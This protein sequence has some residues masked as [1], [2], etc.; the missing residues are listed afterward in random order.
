MG[1]YNEKQEL[2]AAVFWMSNGARFIN[3]LNVSTN[4]GRESG[5]MH[6]LVDLFIRSNCGK[7]MFIDFEGSSIE[8]I[9][10]FYQSFGA[11]NHP[12][13]RRFE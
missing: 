7:P 9:A 5:A 2:C 6:Y 3:L 1:A 11:E 4:S 13:I 12:Q 10:R 8:T